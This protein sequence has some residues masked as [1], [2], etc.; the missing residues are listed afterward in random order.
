MAGRGHGPQGAKGRPK[1]EGTTERRPSPPW[2]L[3]MPS[4]YSWLLG[5]SQ[6]LHTPCSPV[7]GD[8]LNHLLC[9]CILQRDAP[10]RHCQNHLLELASS[11]PCLAVGR[12]QTPLQIWQGSSPPA[13][14]RSP[15]DPV[16]SATHLDPCCKGSCRRDG[17]AEPGDQA[18]P[19]YNTP[20]IHSHY[21][22]AYRRGQTPPPPVLHPPLH[23]VTGT[24]LL[25]AT[26]PGWEQA[27]ACV[28]QEDSFPHHREAGTSQPLARHPPLGNSMVPSWG[29]GLR[30]GHFPESRGWTLNW[31]FS[32]LAQQGL[33]ASSHRGNDPA[34]GSSSH[35]FSFGFFYQR[36]A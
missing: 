29:S 31:L 5:N 34:D 20:G 18:C 6:A 30:R 3:K 28:L 15:P 8:V 12:H 21:C 22:H 1:L 16:Q 23:A 33:R 32:T 25:L 26:F 27:A 36:H 17:K 2:W 4:V 11:H 13:T 35:V 7:D 9:V 24:A 14:G 19:P 10:R